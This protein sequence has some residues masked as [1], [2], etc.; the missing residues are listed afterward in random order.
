MIEDVFGMITPPSQLDS[1]AAVLSSDG[2]ADPIHIPW[3]EGAVLL[4]GTERVYLDAWSYAK[5]KQ[6]MLGRSN[7]REDADGG[8][9]RREFIPNWSSLEFSNFVAKL[10]SIIDQSVAAVIDRVAGQA[11]EDI[12]RRVETKWKSLLAA[13]AAFWPRNGLDVGEPRDKPARGP[14][15]TIVHQYQAPKKAQFR[16]APSA[17]TNATLPGYV[18]FTRD[19][20]CPVG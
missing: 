10:G 2:P 16:T 11:R 5:S 3:L 9:L 19:V 1:Q 8:A 13:E 17:G 18:N 14:W 7:V 4:W 6:P 20:E 15:R 12:L